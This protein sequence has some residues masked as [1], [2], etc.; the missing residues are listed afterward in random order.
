MNQTFLK[1]DNL[2]LKFQGN[3]VGI[4]SIDFGNILITNMGP[5]Y[6]PLGD[7]SRFGIVNEN[8]DSDDIQ[9]L[10]NSIEGVTK[11]ISS[12]DEYASGATWMCFKAERKDQDTILTAKFENFEGEAP[13]AFVFFVKAEEVRHLDKKYKKGGLQNFSGASSFVDIVS[14]KKKVSIA[15]DFKTSMQI[16]PLGGDESYF[17]S[18]FIIAFEILNPKNPNVF[19][20]KSSG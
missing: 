18:D 20:L 1:L 16:I 2:S 8:S 12:N 13:F 7:L 15:P 9:I 6:L 5:H 3:R 14:G 4:G 19:V 11:L 10:D 17:G